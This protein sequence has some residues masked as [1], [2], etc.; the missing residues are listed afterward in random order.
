MRFISGGYFLDSVDGIDR[1]EVRS[2]GFRREAGPVF[3]PDH[4]L[5]NLCGTEPST[6]EEWYLLHRDLGLLEQSC[7]QWFVCESDLEFRDLGEKM[8]DPYLV[9]FCIWKRNYR[10]P[11]RVI[12]RVLQGASCHSDSFPCCER[13]FMS[14]AVLSAPN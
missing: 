4:S 2:D 14:M 1:V 13:V 12:P 8:R 10:I 11:G 7:G 5:P 6:I 3:S 9:K